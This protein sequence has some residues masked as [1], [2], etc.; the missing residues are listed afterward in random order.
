MACKTRKK[1]SMRPSLCR[2]WHTSGPRTT[3]LKQT[4]KTR[5]RATT[6]PRHYEAAC[7]DGVASEAHDRLLEGC[8]R[9]PP[10]LRACRAPHQQS[11]SRARGATLSGPLRLVGYA[12][13][14][15]F[16]QRRGRQRGHRHA[17]RG[18]R[19]GPA[20]TPHRLRQHP[21]VAA[22]LGAACAA[23]CSRPACVQCQAL[24]WVARREPRDPAQRGVPH[25]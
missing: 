15:V 23:E 16:G 19:G 14:V 18:E 25:L 10:S 20:P 17:C 21:C 24:R 13:P 22:R 5:A 8:G 4:P 3:P 2:W 9:R 7:A 6:A 1:L 12:H 11:R